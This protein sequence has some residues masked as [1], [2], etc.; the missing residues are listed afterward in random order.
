[1][2][3]LFTLVTHTQI[4]HVTRKN[5][6]NNGQL[7]R[8]QKWKLMA[9]HSFEKT[10]LRMYIHY[11]HRFNNYR[12]SNTAFTLFMIASLYNIITKRSFQ[13]KFATSSQTLP[14][15]WSIP[16][17]Q[18]YSKVIPV[19]NVRLQYLL[20]QYMQVSSSTETVHRQVYDTHKFSHDTNHI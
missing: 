4:P 10:S 13:V 15:L 11:H 5:F 3:G 9:P 14:S 16:P 6:H 1:M 18:Y 2:F 17:H 12:P 20:L 8:A 19:L 7:I